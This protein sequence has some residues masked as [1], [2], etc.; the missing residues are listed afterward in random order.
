MVLALSKNLVDWAQVVGA[1]VGLVA[2]VVALVSIKQA[3]AS[4]SE[5]KDAADA[6]KAIAENTAEQLQVVRDE[7]A[8]AAVERAKGPRL[9][10]TLHAWPDD[11]HASKHSGPTARLMAQ[12]HNGGERAA[13]YATL[14]LRVQGQRVPIVQTAGDG[15]D[16]GA[17]ERTEVFSA[18]PPPRSGY[19]T[20]L[21]QWVTLPAGETLTFFFRVDPGAGRTGVEAELRH[22]GDPRGPATASGWLHLGAA[23][24]EGVWTWESGGIVADLALAEAVR[25]AFD[26]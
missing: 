25:V 15:P 7:A 2:L 1:G 22:G 21:R 6:S 12:L 3:A 23:T 16:R 14:S 13:E 20:Q 19:W 8:A 10:L 4:A 9:Q 26:A 17:V 18:H 24:P 5:A 11:E